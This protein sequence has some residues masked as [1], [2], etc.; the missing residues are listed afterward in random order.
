MFNEINDKY[1]IAPIGMSVIF[2]M[3]IAFT[4]WDLIWVVNAGDWDGLGRFIV[5]FLWSVVLAISLGVND[6][7]EVPLFKSKPKD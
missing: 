2:Y 6:L 1:F 3:L 5:F 7:A 4:S